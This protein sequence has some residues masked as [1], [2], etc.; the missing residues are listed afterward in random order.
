MLI[1]DNFIP[2]EEKAKLQARAIFDEDE[3]A[4]KLQPCAKSGYVL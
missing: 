2:P 4:W 3:D 1:I